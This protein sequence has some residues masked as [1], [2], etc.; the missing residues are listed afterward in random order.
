MA[1]LQIILVNLQQTMRICLH[2]L[3]L[4]SERHTEKQHVVC[5][6]AKTP[7][8]PLAALPADEGSSAHRREKP[9]PAEAKS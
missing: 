3:T 1:E 5:L 9:L 4:Q 2:A 7:Q 6:A 8:Q